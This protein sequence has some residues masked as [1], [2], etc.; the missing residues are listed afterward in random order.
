MDT[1]EKLLNVF[2]QARLLYLVTFC[3]LVTVVGAPARVVPSCDA[4]D[5][6]MR[7]SGDRAES[8]LSGV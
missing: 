6:E 1:V 7:D 4:A 2:Y 8:W 3:C 5:G